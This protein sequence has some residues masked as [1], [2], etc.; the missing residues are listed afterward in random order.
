[1]N[2]YGLFA[3]PSKHSLSPKMHNRAFYELEIDANYEA[4]DV[5]MSETE[6]GRIEELKTFL[7]K[8]RE[9][10]IIGANLSMPN[11]SIAVRFMDELSETARLTNSVNTILSKDG[12]LYGYST[13]GIGFER[14]LLDKNINLSGKKVVLAGCGG[15]GT[16]IYVRC[17]LSGAKEIVLFNRSGKRFDEA[18]ERIKSLKDRCDIKLFNLLDREVLEREVK[19]ADILVNATGLGMGDCIGKTWV[20]DSSILNPKTVCFDAIYNPFETRFLEMAK[21]RGCD[22]ING[23]MMLIYQGAESFKIWTGREMPI[24]RVLEEIKMN[25]KS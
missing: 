18:K 6:E 10:R 4:Y 25:V 13:D 3:Y 15:A 7:D 17:A 21:R 5:G 20:Y 12:K 2:Q 11:K 24:D 23:L 14:A 19:D 9:G 8:M 22:T 16:A 1:M